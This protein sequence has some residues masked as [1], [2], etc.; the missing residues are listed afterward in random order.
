[1][2]WMTIERNVRPPHTCRSRHH[3]IAATSQ[4]ERN[5]SL[6][7][8]RLSWVRLQT[9]S[10]IV[11]ARNS[12]VYG[13]S[14]SPDLRVLTFLFQETLF[15]AFL[16]RCLSFGGT[17]QWCAHISNDADELQLLWGNRAVLSGIPDT[18]KLILFHSTSQLL[19]PLAA[20]I[21]IDIAI[22]S[23]CMQCNIHCLRLFNLPVCIHGSG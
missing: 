21:S 17:V 23:L 15:S 4:P 3:L 6:S 13:R 12:V 16:Y 22:T 11:V 1:M 8:I 20:F 10:L 5:V 19:F 14:A 7:W 2:R 9:D 18:K